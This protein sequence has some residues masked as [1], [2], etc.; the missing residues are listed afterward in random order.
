MK[1]SKV[2]F[3]RRDTCL[4]AIFAMMLVFVL[5]FIVD[6]VYEASLI[7]AA[8]ALGI[9][10]VLCRV[11]PV[12]I[13]EDGTRLKAR[14]TRMIGRGMS[15]LTKRKR[16]GGRTCGRREQIASHGSLSRGRLHSFSKRVGDETR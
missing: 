13:E 16:S 5:W 14:C 8:A 12:L 2:Y 11:K 9:Y 6:G 15:A 1:N 10:L 7:F 3:S 4:V